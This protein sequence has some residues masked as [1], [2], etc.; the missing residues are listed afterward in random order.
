M[1]TTVAN[2]LIQSGTVTG[3]RRGIKA[4]AK[5]TVIDAKGKLVCPGFIDLHAH[6]R[7]PGFEYKETIQTGSAAAVAG[8]FTTIIT[9]HF[10]KVDT[11]T[12]F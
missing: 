3:I 9:T 5:C 7:E 12:T 10:S 2:V 6:L 11:S 8:G 4:Y 1:P